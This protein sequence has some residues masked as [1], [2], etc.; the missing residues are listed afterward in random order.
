MLPYI[1]VYVCML[2]V[3]VCCVPTSLMC[4]LRM[5]TM[6]A[7]VLNLSTSASSTCSIHNVCD[8]GGVG[9][10]GEIEIT[11]FM[12]QVHTI[13]LFQSEGIIIVHGLCG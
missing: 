6:P 12:G 8:E 13:Y 4:V 3:F 2:C 5:G 10:L 1:L 7:T 9:A 11:K